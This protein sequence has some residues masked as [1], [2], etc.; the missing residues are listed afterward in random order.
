MSSGCGWHDPE[1][2]KVATGVV[3]DPQTDSSLL[4]VAQLIHHQAWF[5]RLINEEAHLRTRNDDAHGAGGLAVGSRSE[6]D[7]LPKRNCGGE[8]GSAAG[9]EPRR[10]QAHEAEHADGER[11]RCRI[12]GRQAV[13]KARC[14]P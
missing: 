4:A 14:I 13:K 5:F 9:G 12:Q 11:E 10:E 2:G 7:L 6:W 1:V 3:P 8:P